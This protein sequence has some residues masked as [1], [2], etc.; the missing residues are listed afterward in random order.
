MLPRQLLRITISNKGKH[1]FPVFCDIQRDLNLA[2]GIINII[3]LSI[4]NKEK[5]SVI[6]KEILE[7][8]R[9]F[10]VDYRLVQGL[11]ELINRRCEYNE[12]FNIEK[13]GISYDGDKDVSSSN[14]IE[15]KD[16]IFLR[17]LVFE[18]SSK[19]G[20]AITLVDR[21]KILEKI[22]ARLNVSKEIIEKLLWMDVEDNQIIRSYE[23]I[24]PKQ[25]IGWY[26]LSILQTVL[27]SCTKLEFSLN[28][29]TNWKKVL[30]LVKK[31]GLMYTLRIM[32]NSISSENLNLIEGKKRYD[33]NDRNN[34]YI[35][36][37]S[38]ICSI[39]GPLSIFKLTEKYGTSIAKI[40]S[41]IVTLDKWRINASVLRKSL[42]SGKL[43]ELH[44]SNENSILFTYPSSLKKEI[45]D[46]DKLLFDSKIEEIF[47]EKFELFDKGWKLIREPDPLILTDNSAFIPDF[48]IRK[49][50]VQI[51]IEIIGFWTEEYL[52]RKFNKIKDILKQKNN[53]TEFFFFI[54]QDVSLTN[55]FIQKTIKEIEKINPHNFIFYKNNNITIKPI[56]DRLN[57][58][59]NFMITNIAKTHNERI[60]NIIEKILKDSKIDIISLRAISKSYNFPFEALIH[61]INLYQKNWNGIFYKIDEFLVSVKKLNVIKQQM[62]K[63]VSLEDAL[64]VIK[65]NGIPETCS[66][67]IIQTLGYD[68]LWNGINVNNATISKTK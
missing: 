44:I 33:L 16:P 24:G 38:I 36:D 15:C 23:P 4:K 1:I 64:K 48:L 25:L 57:S 29:G 59:D 31:F 18:E 12:N 61:S 50:D 46:K 56:I 53:R 21:D 32:S 58:I 26:N 5:K 43:Y 13:E 20:L 35:E 60:I 19:C 47:A 17:R 49:Y 28:G 40:I 39:D 42:S 22:A 62:K 52:K 11:Y 63:I 3:E 27:F 65:Q 10:N 2:T 37:K 7:L 54:N 9:K 8:E 6:G 68:I 41:F 30:R 14:L 55:Y 34:K 45:T 66:I 51:Y 67:Q